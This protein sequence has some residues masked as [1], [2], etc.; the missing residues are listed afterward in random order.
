MRSQAW[1]A[2]KKSMVALS[3]WALV[4]LEFGLRGFPSSCKGCLVCCHTLVRIATASV[5]TD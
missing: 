3:G 2:A 4:N 5:A 1:T